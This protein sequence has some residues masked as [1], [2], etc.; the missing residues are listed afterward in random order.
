M[1]ENIILYNHFHNGDL[2]FNRCIIHLLKKKYKK[3]TVYHNNPTPIFEDLPIVDEKNKIPENFLAHVDNFHNTQNGLVNGWI[4]QGNYHYLNKINHGC[5][6]ENYLSMIHDISNYLGIPMIEK[7]ELLPIVN[8]ESLPL[9][10]QVVGKMYE[11]KKKFKKIVLLSNGNVMSAQS[12]NFNF[13][14]I[15]DKLSTKFCDILFIMTEKKDINKIN[16]ISTDEIT[17]TKPDLLYISLISTF[18]DVVVG[19]DSGP[20]CFSHVKEN[21]MNPNKKFICISNNYDS[22]KFYSESKVDYVW[23]NSYNLNE[24]LNIIESKILL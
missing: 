24:I 12:V 10:K 17:K 9:Y 16:V 19:R 23:S 7:E 13:D 22:G 20:Y 14:D 21:L 4:G 11:F 8:F 15:I 2:F 5:T 1:N 18:V 3:I 6:F